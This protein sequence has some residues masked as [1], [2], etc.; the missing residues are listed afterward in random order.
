[1][2]LQERVAN[3]LGVAGTD[4]PIEY[5]ENSMLPYRV[6]TS[7]F[8]K[9]S[10]TPLFQLGVNGYAFIVSNNGY[11]LTHP[12][13]RP[14]VSRENN[15][16]V[17]LIISIFQYQGILKPAYNRVDITEIEIMDDDTDPRQFSPE[18]LEFRKR[19]VMQK[20]G[21][22]T[23]RVK[24]HM[25]DMVLKVLFKHFAKCLSFSVVC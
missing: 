14:V 3:L 15:Y 6:R 1:M 10:L 13:L 24:T 8:I 5:I 2:F 19:V 18:I 23:L 20:K 7:T 11:I 22:L 16:K 9:C 21:N 25:D 12:D 4:I 17:V